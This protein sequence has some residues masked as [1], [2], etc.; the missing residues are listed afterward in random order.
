MPDLNIDSHMNVS[1][2]LKLE[3]HMSVIPDLNIEL[4]NIPSAKGEEEQWSPITASS[5]S[6]I[7]GRPVNPLI[8]ILWEEQNEIEREDKQLD[9]LRKNLDRAALNLNRFK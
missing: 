5:S 1:P 7:D 9:I 3:S 8:N 2:D 4:F 6:T